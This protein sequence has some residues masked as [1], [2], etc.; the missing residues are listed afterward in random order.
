MTRY[1]VSYFRTTTE[2]VEK[3]IDAAPDLDD[4]EYLRLAMEAEEDADTFIKDTGDGDY[5]LHEVEALEET[6]S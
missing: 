1:R 5:E 4:D 6:A 2:I 3:I